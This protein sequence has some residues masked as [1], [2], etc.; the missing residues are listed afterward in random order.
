MWF[1]VFRCD[2]QNIKIELL[3]NFFLVFKHWNIWITEDLQTWKNPFNTIQFTCNWKSGKNHEV[4]ESIFR[5]Y[6]I[7]FAKTFA[8]SS[9]VTWF[10]WLGS[11]SHGNRK[12][13]KSKQKRNK[14]ISSKLVCVTKKGTQWIDTSIYQLMNE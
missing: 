11:K 6:H 4:V 3:I 7:T 14:T 12:Q 9:F 8:L 2:Y 1:S 13:A 5:Q 10:K